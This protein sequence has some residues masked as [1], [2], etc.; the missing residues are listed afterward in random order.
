MFK[1]YYSAI[2][3]LTTTINK[4]VFDKSNFLVYYE[5]IA[6]RK[7][8]HILLLTILIALI[9]SC[10]SN[11]IDIYSFIW[12]NLIKCYDLPS[13]DIFKKVFFLLFYLIL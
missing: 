6:Y 13:K 5:D 12:L 10:N 2:I 3:H 11:Y 9:S 8:S 4:I 7:F 1:K